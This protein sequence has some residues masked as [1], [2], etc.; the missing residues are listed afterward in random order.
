MI[1]LMN[2]TDSHIESLSFTMKDWDDETL[3]YE[4]ALL[5]TRYEAIRLLN[6]V[7][8]GKYKLTNENKRSIRIYNRYCRDAGLKPLEIPS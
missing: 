5:Q 2:D 1:N 7:A 4:E 6:E 8:V 3:S